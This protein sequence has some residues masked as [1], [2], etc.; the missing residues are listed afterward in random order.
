[1]GVKIE[2]LNGLVKFLQQ[3][4]DKLVQLFLEDLDRLG[5]EAVAYIR[6]RTADQSWIDQTGNLRSSI[7][8]VIVQNGQIVNKG[9]FEA[10]I[11]PKGNDANVNGTEQG[12]TYAEQIAGRYP[13]GY[14]L[15]VVAGMNYAAYVEAK[16]NK[17]VLASGEIF[18]RK[19][20]QRLVEQYKQEYGQ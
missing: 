16:E 10:V 14:A 11:G 17:D 13:T 7:G 9:G 2:G 20:M 6:D 4:T 1:M 12:A 8:Y 19:E 3:R 18:L 15:I 5:L